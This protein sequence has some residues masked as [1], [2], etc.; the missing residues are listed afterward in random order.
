MYGRTTLLAVLMVVAAA[1]TGFAV[2]AEAARPDPVPFKYTAAM[3][4]TAAVQTQMAETSLSV[5]RAEV[6]YSQYRYAVGVYGVGS[7][8]EELGREGRQHQFGAPIVVYVSDYAGLDPWVGEEGLL[9]APQDRTPRWVPVQEAFF[10]AGSRAG[11]PSGDAVVPF[12]DRAAAREFA[13]E[14][15]GEVRRWPAVRGMSFATGEATRERYRNRVRERRAWADDAAGDAGRLLERPVSVVVGE[16]APNLTAA[17]AA[18]PANTTV[19][20]PAGTYHLDE[21]TVDKPLTLRGAGN[22]TTL[23]GDGNGSVVRVRAPRVGVANLS[24]EGVGGNVTPGADVDESEWDSRIQRGYGFGP[25]G[26]EFEDSERSLVHGVTVHTPANGVVVRRSDGVVVEG[27]TVL[28]SED[29]WE[30]FMGVMV[31]ES[32]VVVQ[33]STFA[34]GRDGVY[35]HR[36][37]GSVVRNSTFTG[38]RFG[39]HEMY[40][41]HTLLADNTARETDIGLVV[42]T[43]PT[44]NA[45]VGNDVRDSGTGVRVSGSDSYVAGNVVVDNGHGLDVVSRRSLWERNVVADNDVG[46]S[47]DTLLPTNTVVANDFVGNRHHATATLG[48][49]RIWGADGRGNYWSGAPGRDEDGDG[50]LDRAYRATSPLDG[51][52]HRVA[53]TDVLAQSPAVALW[54]SLSS[55]APGLRATGVADYAPR[56]RPVRPDVVERVAGDGPAGRTAP[57]A[58]TGVGP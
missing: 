18:A 4:S 26:V 44:D 8:V 12:S 53:G 16:E 36:G 52:A 34:G 20:L 22:A 38:M 24:I 19:A 11:T 58:T 49:L 39:V 23:V 32:R 15:G 55:V 54:R 43:R 21:V 2:D 48:P 14:Y 7:L 5:P 37:D 45:L 3:G 56:A 46:A 35:T 30:G 41:S 51:R 50:T 27:T 47:A 6:F 31:M 29:W 10:V 42:M 25:A 9:R 33:A 57:S 1:S 17:V 13:R 40:T 28:G